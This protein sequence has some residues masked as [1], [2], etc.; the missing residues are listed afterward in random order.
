[1]TVLKEKYRN[2]LI[3]GLLLLLPNKTENQIQKKANNIGLYKPPSLLWNE[4]DVKMLKKE[5]PHKIIEELQIV[6]PDKMKQ[7]INKKAKR[8]K[9]RKTK[10]TLARCF[11][12]EID[13]IP[14]TPSKRTSWRL[15]ILKRDKYCCQQCNCKDKTGLKLQAHHIKPVRDCNN[16]EKYNIDNGICLC[17]DCHIDIKNK[18]YEHINYFIRRR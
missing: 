7:Q 13:K 16:K 3:K 1:V 10:E 12:T 17:L 5:Y 6:F 18:E 11:R 14:K 15:R 8:L 4:E 2:V 9:L